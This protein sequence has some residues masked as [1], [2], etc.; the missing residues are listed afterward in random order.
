MTCRN[1]INNNV[2]WFGSVGLNSDGTAIKANSIATE[3]Q[4]VAV[5]LTQRLQVLKG[6]LWYAVSY[7]VPL[8]DKVKQKTQM[9]MFVLQTVTGHPDVSA[10][11]N[12]ESTI[13]NSKYSCS[14]TIISKFGELSLNI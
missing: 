1:M 13:V 3:Q 8:F 4:S 14:M 10:I 6:E 7:G 11:T 2:V 12:F 5:S 9:D